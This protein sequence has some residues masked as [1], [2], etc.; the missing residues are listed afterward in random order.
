[1]WSHYF[2]LLDGANQRWTQEATALSGVQMSE[3]LS[4]VP[5]SE[6]ETKMKHTPQSCDALIL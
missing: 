1:M 3:A 2:L 6:N 5:V 4:S